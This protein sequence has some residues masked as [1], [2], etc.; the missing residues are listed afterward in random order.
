MLYRYPT[1][2]NTWL[3][4]NYS[5]SFLFYFLKIIYR[6]FYCCLLFF[7]PKK[8]FTFLLG[9]YEFHRKYI[10]CWQNFW[11]IEHWV[12]VNWFG[13]WEIIIFNC[14]TATAINASIKIV[15]NKKLFWNFFL[16]TWFLLLIR[17]SN[18]LL[19]YSQNSLH[20]IIQM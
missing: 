3:L 18:S 13:W 15:N 2:L 10:I 7:K 4:R 16:F 19:C 6:Y 20:C 11:L 8:Y 5:F 14:I 17:P 9:C 12:Q 1:L